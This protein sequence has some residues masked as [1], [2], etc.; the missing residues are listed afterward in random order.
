M[1][2]LSR[3]DESVTFPSSH[4][5]DW[6]KL[7]ELVGPCRHDPKAARE[8]REALVRAIAYQQLTAKAGDVIIG[9]LKGLSSN[10]IF[11]PSIQLDTR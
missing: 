2:L 3:Y 5:H 7:I 10:A 6:A 8:S 4:D 11:H 1:N 9:R